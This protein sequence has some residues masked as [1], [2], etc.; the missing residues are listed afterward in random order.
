MVVCQATPNSALL[1]PP[2]EE[3][4][5]VGFGRNQFGRFSL[6]GAYNPRTGEDKEEEES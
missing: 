4:M 6:A 2:A 5:V 3:V 1:V